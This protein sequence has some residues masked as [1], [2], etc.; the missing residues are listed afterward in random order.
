MPRSSPP[1]GDEGTEGYRLKADLI[2]LVKLPLYYL[3]IAR[4][5][6]AHLIWSTARALSQGAGFMPTMFLLALCGI[7]FAGSAL[8]QN[9]LGAW[10]AVAYN[11]FAWSTWGL[12][13][14]LAIIVAGWDSVTNVRRLGLRGI[15][16][17]RFW[18]EWGRLLWHIMFLVFATA[19]AIS[20][21][22]GPL[23]AI[24][25]SRRVWQISRDVIVPIFPA[26]I[27]AGII[28]YLVAVIRWSLP[29]GRAFE[30]VNWF[31]MLLAA[32]YFSEI[33]LETWPP[34]KVWPNGVVFVGA[35]VLLVGSLGL[36]FLFG[37]QSWQRL[38]DRSP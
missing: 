2:E 15:L 9:W 16:R 7:V 33:V 28:G 13:A 35:C 6:P 27:V 34:Q 38:E 5:V 4:P 23:G 29:R 21:I 19:T 26:F 25:L 10:A 30:C 32:M 20:W 36:L 3:H 24:D 1:N 37:F 31:L 12:V 11:I 8:L 14:Y 22:A 18:F 17:S